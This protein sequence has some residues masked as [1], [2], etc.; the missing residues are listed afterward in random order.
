MKREA[1][2]VCKTGIPGD[3]EKL[4]GAAKHEGGAVALLWRDQ[5]VA[6][7]EH[8]G[9]TESSWM[10]LSW[11]HQRILGS[12]DIGYPFKLVFATMDTICLLHRSG[13]EVRLRFG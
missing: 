5:E 12:V 13:V 6:E 3:L 2:S 4:C 9:A 7:L 1:V 8:L 11:S 10:G